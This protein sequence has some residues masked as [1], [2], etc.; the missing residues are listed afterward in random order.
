MKTTDDVLKFLA[1]R[2]LISLN[3]LEKMAGIPQSTLSKAKNGHMGL[4]SKHL[5]KLVAILSFY[6]LNNYSDK[7][8]KAA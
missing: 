6:G 5:E 1:N 7:P 8:K 2:P 3:K 4:P